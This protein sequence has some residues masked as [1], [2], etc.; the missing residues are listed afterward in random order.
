MSID[1]D[2]ISLGLEWRVAQGCTQKRLL[3]F[4][5]FISCMLYANYVVFLADNPCFL[6]DMINALDEYCGRTTIFH[7]LRNI[8]A[9][10]NDDLDRNEN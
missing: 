6:L 7:K 3:L 9:Y 1:D 5:L 4:A 8:V 2:E 10:A